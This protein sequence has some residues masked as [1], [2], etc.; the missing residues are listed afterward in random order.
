MVLRMYSA[1]V[2]GTIRSV[3]ICRGKRVGGTVD[4]DRLSGVLGCL[5]IAGYSL[6]YRDADMKHW[7][8]G[9]LTLETGYVL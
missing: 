3:C 9:L 1:M 4:E 6:G 7:K 8:N 5:R 2:F